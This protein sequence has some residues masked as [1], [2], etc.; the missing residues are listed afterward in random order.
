MKA[1]DVKKKLTKK[2]KTKKLTSKDYLSTGCVLLNLALTDKP[3]RGFIKGK[4]YYIVG[5]SSS[6]KTFLTLTCLAEAGINPNFKDY[7]FIYDN[8]EDGALMNIEKFFGKAVDKRME[9][10]S[11]YKGEAVYSE[12]IEDFYYHVDD[13]IQDGRPFIYIQ[14]SMD[15]LSSAAENKKFD[16]NKKASRKGKKSTGSFGDGKAKKNSAGLRRLLSPMKKSGSILII[17]SQTRAN[18]GFGAQFNPKT[19]S[20]G[21][22]LTFYTSLEIWSSVR[23]KIYKTVRGKKRQIGMVSLLKVKKNRFTGKDRQVEVPIYYSYGFDNIGSMV[24][25]LVDENHWDGDKKIKA[26]EFGFEGT[27]EKLIKYIED[28]EM[29]RDLV[30]IVSDVWDEIEAGCKIDRKR[31]Y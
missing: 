22:A 5:D 16:E 30:G 23:K 12:T 15:V 24:D 8:G 6:G 10:P 11:Y 17:L 19:R 25:F 1:K 14:D 9:A 31:R 4:Y 7:R 21:N 20:G 18:I 29:E 27:K 28:N 26:K 2:K 13:A 3:Y